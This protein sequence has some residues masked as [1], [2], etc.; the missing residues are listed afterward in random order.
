MEVWNNGYRLWSG[1]GLDGS[2]VCQS[3]EQR[4]KLSVFP[5][6]LILRLADE[7]NSRASIKSTSILKLIQLNAAYFQ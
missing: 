6:Q 7:R 2:S 4:W 3:M 1:C 5:P